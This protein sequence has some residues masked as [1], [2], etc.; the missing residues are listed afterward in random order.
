MTAY[1]DLKQYSHLY[2]GQSVYG[3]IKRMLI[4]CKSHKNWGFC[5]YIFVI[6]DVRRCTA[7]VV[8]I[9]KRQ[10][11]YVILTFWQ[12]G[13]TE[14]HHSHLRGRLPSCRSR[15]AANRGVAHNTHHTTAKQYIMLTKAVSLPPCFAM[16]L[17]ETICCKLRRK[18]CAINV[19][20]PAVKRIGL[21]FFL[22]AY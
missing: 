1:F 3:H 8:C 17:W 10:L 6:P 13:L 19:E 15:V 4:Q 20:I 7:R 5:H 2:F 21:K 9:V 12:S 14:H 18:E 11:K 16:P 22:W